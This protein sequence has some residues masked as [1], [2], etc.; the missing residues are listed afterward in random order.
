MTVLTKIESSVENEAKQKPNT[1]VKATEPVNNMIN[2][3]SK[4]GS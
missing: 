4:V 2:R 3:Q 1:P